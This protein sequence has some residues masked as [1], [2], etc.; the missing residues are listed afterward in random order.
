MANVL[1]IES[2]VRNSD[3]VSR[4]LADEY[5]QRLPEGSQ[6]VVRD[7]AAN[8]LPH[9]DSDLLS[10]WMVPEVEQSEE[11]KAAAARSAELIA[12]LQAADVLVIATPMYNF[13]I[14]STLKAW[15]DHVLRA[16]VTFRYT[17]NG[18]LGLLEGKRAVIISARGGVYAGTP[19]DFVEP[20]LVQVMKFIGITDIDCV[21]AEGMNL[22]EEVAASGVAAAREVLAGVAA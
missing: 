2:S 5:L 22:G 4:T 8:P 13:G 16:G 15:L 9:L 11:Q 6:V 10:G 3:S 21:H 17:E 18:P 7:V 20:Y 14:P 1:L 19:I 12:E